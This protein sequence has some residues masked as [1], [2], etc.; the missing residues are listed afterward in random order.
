VTEDI[1]RGDYFKGAKGAIPGTIDLAGSWLMHGMIPRIKL[2]SFQDMAAN[3]LKEADHNNWSEEEIRSRMQSA[4]D[5]VDNRYGQMVYDNRFWNRVALEIAQLGIRSVGWQGGTYMEYGGGVTDAAKAFARAASRKKPEVTH[6]LAFSLATPIYTALIAAVGTYLMTGHKPDTDKYG[7]KAY[8]MIETADGTMLSIPGY[9]KNLMSVGE[10]VAQNGIPWRTA[11]NTASP[12][13]STSLEMM[14]NKDYYGNEIRNEDD[15]YISKT[16]GKSQAG[17]YGKFIASQYIPFTVKSFQQQRQ[18]A[19]EGEFSDISEGKSSGMSLLSYA[20]F[21]PAT[22][23]MQNSSAMNLAEHYRNETPQAPRTAE[24]AE[25]NRTFRNLVKAL[26]NGNLN[27]EKL[28]EAMEKGR[29][30]S[31]QYSEAVR[32]ARWTPLER[33]TSRLSFTQAMKVWQKANPQEKASLHDLMAEKSQHQLETVYEQ[34]G[35]EAA[36][37]LQARLKQQGILTE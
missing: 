25:H 4:W 6:K 23:V 12:A 2:G 10:D 19:G 9:S 28:N 35:D 3:I 8:S 36:Q 33:V 22:Q 26:E 37:T 16:L 24:Q 7:L 17:E 11:V 5:S 29:I 14:Q 32:E 21:Q 18:R 30:T 20:G 13:I 1:R 27:Q 34:E 15:P 31:R